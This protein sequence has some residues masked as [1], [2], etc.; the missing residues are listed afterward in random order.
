MSIP[1]S[2]WDRLI[3]Q[4]NLLF[5]KFSFNSVVCIFISG[6]PGGAEGMSSILGCPSLD[7]EEYLV[8]GR[9]SVD[10]LSA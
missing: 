1:C 6:D 5:L 4:N 2:I 10:S 9:C 3:L 7:L 8:H